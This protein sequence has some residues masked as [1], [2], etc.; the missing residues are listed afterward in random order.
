LLVQRGI[1]ESSSREFAEF[2]KTLR[3][4]NGLDPQVQLGPLISGSSWTAYCSTS[5]SAP[6]K[7]PNSL[8]GKRLQGELAGGYFVEPTIFTRSDQHHDDRREE[9]FWTGGFGDSVR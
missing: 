1:Q 2:S 4:G 3:V 5:T 7:A 6:R 9:I 8:G